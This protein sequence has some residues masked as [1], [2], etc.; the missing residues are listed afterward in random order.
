MNATPPISVRVVRRFRASPERVYDAWLDPRRAAAFLFATDGGTMVAAET[1][2]RVGGRF[3]FV[4]RR[5]GEDVEHHGT[6]L[7][8]DRPRRL[9][10][11]FHVGQVD[12]GELSRVT[13]DIAPL[14]AGCELTLVHEMDARWADYAA[15]TEAGW[16]SILEG[17]A[18]LEMEGSEGR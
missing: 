10:F 2:P 9:V 8:L 5:D 6:Y 1:D 15:R 4:D 17:L 18:R 14:D 7:E 13:I 16:T 3:R 12:A 11:T